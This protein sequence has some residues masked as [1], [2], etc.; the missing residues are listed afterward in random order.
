VFSS[1]RF[2]L[3]VTLM[4]V[5]VVGLG[6]A[7]LLA[8]R[9]TITQFG[10][11]LQR[12][13]TMR[14]DRFEALLAG[15]YA[16]NGDWS[17]VQP[18]VD[19]IAQISGD[20]IVLTD[21]Q[22]IIVADSEDELVGEQIGR[23]W[24]QPSATILRGSVPVGSVYVSPTGRP[25]GPFEE[26]YLDSIRNTLLWAALAGALAAVV[27]TLLLSRRILAPVEA[28]T[29]A[30]GQMAK[31][32]LSQRVEVRSKDEIGDLGQAFN[33]MA[34]GLTRL[35]DLRQNMVADVAHELRTPLSNI[36]GYLE[37]LR[38]G[39]MDPTPDKLD[40][41]YSQAMLLN[42]LVDDLQELAL[43]DAGQM[44]LDLQWVHPEEIVTGAAEAIRP[45]AEANGIALQVDLPDTLPLLNI[46]HR[47]I[48]QVL[49]NLLKNALTHT[50]SGGDITVTAKAS[51]T[52]LEIS[53][54]DTGEGIPPENLPH[55]FERFYRVDKSRSREMGGAGLGLAIAKHL[56]E[57][58]GGSIGA[59][60]EQGR[61]A[62]FTF[63]LP[64][65]SV[66]QDAPSEPQGAGNHQPIGDTTV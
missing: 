51:E 12:G 4:L 3:L 30:A 53:V 17:G 59:R 50:P 52:E 23:D 65:T 38:D 2:R 56:V 45:Q 64:T 7:A 62:T 21:G 11:Y 1:L 48:G 66:Q 39:V 42:H 26:A 44:K 63:T 46:D 19:Q 57:A 5:A 8:S 25:R 9:G 14:R 54:T 29:S 15:Y 16:R 60:S 28:L 47:R 34:D 24:S 40:L 43:A 36:R 35:E 49:T 27:L 37:A 6:V 55:V 61:G 58:H 33:T 18:L 10:R 13:A 31:G 32:D 41:I 22:G 20:R